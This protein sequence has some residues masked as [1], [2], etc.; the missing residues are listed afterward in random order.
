MTKIDQLR[1]AL[2]TLHPDIYLRAYLIPEDIA[3]EYEA[4]VEVVAA[5]RSWLAH[6]EEN[7]G[8]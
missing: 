6:L 3:H 2:D 7:R 5:A 4:W 8:N 1:Q